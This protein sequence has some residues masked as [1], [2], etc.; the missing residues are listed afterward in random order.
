MIV[1][2]IDGLSVVGEAENGLQAVKL[3]R[4][5][6]P[7]IVLMDV[8][9]PI[10]DGIEA[11]KRILRDQ[12]A[13]R[14]L[15]LTMVAKS[16]V[17][18][19]AIQAGAHGYLLKGAGKAEIRRAI[20]AV[21][22]GQ[23]LFGAA[24]AQQISSLI[25]TKVAEPAEAARPFPDLTAREF[26]IL[27]LMVAG[28]NNNVIAVRLGIRPKTVRNYVSKIL[29]TLAVPDRSAAIDHALAVGITP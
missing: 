19:R 7:D 15:I 8:D 16:D 18:F 29:T 27:Q 28:H 12:A 6:Q 25:Q 11:T 1:S 20:E 14:V 24:I 9:M 5:L 26:E 23:L 4:E 10:L 22:D 21:A 3:A 17:L 13:V 2:T